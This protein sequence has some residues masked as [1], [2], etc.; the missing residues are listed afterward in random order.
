MLRWVMRGIEVD[1]SVIDQDINLPMLVE[2]EVP[3]SHDTHDVRHLHL[4]EL[5][6]AARTFVDT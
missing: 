4:L 2:D 1:G 6:A 5:Q 3:Q